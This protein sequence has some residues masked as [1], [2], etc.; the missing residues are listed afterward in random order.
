MKNMKASE[1]I[2]EG[3]KQAEERRDLYI[4]HSPG[5]PTCGCALGLGAIGLLGAEEAKER[6]LN[7]PGSPPVILGNI[8]GLSEEIA[9]EVE[10]RHQAGIESASDLANWLE[11]EGY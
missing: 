8:I 6:Y 7:T 11:K 1:A 4:L 2:R 5:V 3:L 10:R 9:R